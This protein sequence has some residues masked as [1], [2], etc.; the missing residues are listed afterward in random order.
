MSRT[1]IVGGKI[2]EIVHGD[3]NIYSASDIIFNS[4][5]T[6]IPNGKK[7]IVIGNKVEKI[8]SKD[9]SNDEENNKPEYIVEFKHTPSY[10]GE[11]GF[12]WMRGNWLTGDC[13]EGLEELKKIYT[14]FQVNLKHYQTQKPYGDYYVPW[15]IMF[16][17]HKE[18]IGKEVQ[19]LVTAPME[20]QDSS[21][22]N[23]TEDEEF[24]LKTSNPSLRVEPSKLNINDC[25][26]GAVITIYCDSPL[27]N[28]ET[29]TAIASNGAIV[30]K[31]NVMKNSHYQELIINIHIVNVY[32]I[33]NPNFNKSIIETEVNSI[34][35]LQIIE[36]YL[37]KRSLNQALIQVKFQ[38]NKGNT[39]DVGIKQKDLL[40]INEG[41]NPKTNKK[42]EK[43]A[44]FIDILIDKNNFVLDKR[45]VIDLFSLLFKEKYKEVLNTRSII[46]H[47]TSL[48]SKAGGISSI[49]PLDERNSVIF[50]TNLSHLFSYAHE[51][52]HVL[53]LPHTFLNE[54]KNYQQL[55]RE[56]EIYARKRKEIADKIR[57]FIKHAI[58]MRSPNIDKIKSE[59]EAEFI[60]A[61]TQGKKWEIIARDYRKIQKYDIY[62]FR[63]KKTSNIMDYDL[64]D[65]KFFNK[66]QIDIMQS[67]TKKY[68]AKK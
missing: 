63:Q 6:V 1:R 55:A 9:N 58:N 24:S 49:C 14:P 22:L 38:Y 25:L 66:Y 44:P 48:L 8:T 3:Y 32:I 64:N 68:Y 67:E 4:E 65:H 15:L 2:T 45:K 21:L 56:A 47:L 31:I 61:E 51:I 59:N 33:D 19:L 13:V 36:D 53:G 11:F 12:D 16:P 52:G 43:Y 50:K 17:N 18:K 39:Y 46:L 42:S 37:N 7:G 54:G 29:I 28:D 35:G 27:K 26:S 41:K 10:D 5:K 34:G 40:S 23:S 57:N 30:G 62:K 60:E 20:Y